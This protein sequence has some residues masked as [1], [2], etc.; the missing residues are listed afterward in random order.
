ML[1]DAGGVTL[2][3]RL[4]HTA[5]D[6]SRRRALF[7]VATLAHE[8]EGVA[9][10]LREADELASG[11][12]LA[13]LEHGDTEMQA[14]ALSVIYNT[15]QGDA[16]S[17]AERMACRGWWVARGVTSA[18]QDLAQ[19]LLQRLSNGDKTEDD[20]PAVPLRIVKI[21]TLLDSAEPL[22]APPAPPAPRGQLPAVAEAGAA[23][24][25]E[26]SEGAVASAVPAPAPMLALK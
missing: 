23:E 26:G 24:G 16:V 13:A 25:G 15:L 2:L 10:A 3:A 20:D 18:L 21:L 9:Q 4:A 6:K 17:A 14:Q 19:R 7:L 12:V 11:A 8:A 22:G 1:V 5:D